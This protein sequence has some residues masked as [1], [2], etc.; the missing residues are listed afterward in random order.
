MLHIGPW[1]ARLVESPVARR[2]GWL[3]LMLLAAGLRFSAP[4]WDGGLA[5]HPDE[6]YLLG[7]AADAPLGSNICARAPDFPYGHLPILIAQLL[8][9]CAPGR[10]PLYVARLTSALIGLVAIVLAGG[11]GR[12]LAGRWAGLLSATVAAFSPFLI[13]QAHFYTVDPLGMV[14]VNAA[15]LA[16]TRRRWLATGVLC[17]LGVACKL[18]LGVGIVPLC[19]SAVLAKGRRARCG[20]E[21]CKAI[22]GSGPRRLLVGALAAFLLVSPWSLFTPRQC[23]RGPLVQSLMV[24]GRYELPYTL[25]Y[26]GTV[27]Y[28]YPLV[29]M[30]LWGLGL[31]ATAMGAWGLVLAPRRHYRLRGMIASPLWSW[32]VV[33]LLAVGGLSVKFPRYMLP[34]YPIWVA[35]AAYVVR[36]SGRKSRRCRIALGGV[37]VAVTCAMGLAQAGTYTQPH[38]WIVASQRIYATTEPGALVSSEAW[39]H[40]LPVPLTGWDASSFTPVVAPVYDEETREKQL[41]LDT[42]AAQ[43]DVVVVSSRRG[44][45]ALARQPEQYDATL[46]WYAKLLGERRMEAFTR[47]PHIGPL[48]FS[49]NPLSDARLSA[50]LTLAELCGTRWVVRL[51]RLDESYRVYDSPLALVLWRQH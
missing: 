48:A 6:R 46:R 1:F 5:T 2:L 7:V 26:V 21:R 37:L 25:Q 38:P 39:D 43:A 24:S 4:D 16:A 35:W 30:A 3:L 9:R 44:Y 19:A 20:S 28:A 50:S 34:L 51:P 10:D 41:L 31:P 22:W 49:D 32:P 17:G 11:L 18:S 45:G 27:P 29:Q 14:L 42:L 40:P 12:E 23:W 36:Q 15:V 47:C 8:V 13:Q 33:Y